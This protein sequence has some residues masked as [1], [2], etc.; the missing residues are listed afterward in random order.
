[1]HPNPRPRCDTL[2]CIVTPPPC[3]LSITCRQVQSWLGAV[4]GTRSSEDGPVSWRALTTSGVVA[5]LVR[6]GDACVPITLGSPTGTP[7]LLCN[8]TLQYPWPASSGPLPPLRGVVVRV[9]APSCHRIGR[10]VPS[11]S[12]LCV[13]MMCGMVGLRWMVCVGEGG[14]WGGGGASASARGRGSCIGS[15]SGSCISEK[16]ISIY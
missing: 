5:T 13:P 6:T 14:S 9:C 15:G 1:M 11:G 16:H 10:G 3:I 12:L 4:L 8:A 7:P 2:H